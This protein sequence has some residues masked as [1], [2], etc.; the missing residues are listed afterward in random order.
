MNKPAPINRGPVWMQDWLND[1]LDYAA[2]AQPLQGIGTMIQQTKNGTAIN[3]TGSSA[4]GSAINYPFDLT[5]S[6]TSLVVR[7]GTCNGLLPD[8]MFATFTIDPAAVTIVKLRATTDGTAVTGCTLVVTTAAAAAQPPT[9]FGLPASVDVVVGVTTLG[10]VL[11]TIGNGSV[12][13]TGQELFRTDKASPAA[14]GQ[15]DYIPYY[16]WVPTVY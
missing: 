10:S 12:Y 8:N 13:L 7:A 14:P 5:A 4:T 6:G 2:Q 16:G 11:R 3:A 9:P 1:L 15:I